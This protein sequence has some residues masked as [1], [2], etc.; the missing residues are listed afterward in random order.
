MTAGTKVRP[1]SGHAVPDILDLQRC[2]RS[3]GSTVAAAVGKRH[4]EGG[5]APNLVGVPRQLTATVPPSARAATIVALSE[6]GPS[7][8][9]EH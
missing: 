5:P 8:D 1:H 9:P 4:K 3:T 6:I 7:D 2:D